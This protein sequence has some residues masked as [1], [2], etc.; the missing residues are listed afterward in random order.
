LP[1]RRTLSRLCRRRVIARLAVLA[2]LPLALSMC[3]TPDDG[4][5]ATASTTCPAVTVTRTGSQQTAVNTR[6]TNGTWNLRGAYWNKNAPRP[7]GYPVRSD[8]WTRGCIWGGKV[9]GGVPRSWTRDKWYDARDGGIR[10]GGDA[11]RQTMTA[12]AG[13]FLRIQDAFVADY[14]DAYDPD[15]A[16]WSSTTYLD[17]V[18]A[19][20]IRDDC[21]E[22]ESR[23]HNLVMTNSLLDGCFTAFAERPSG[24]TSGTNGSGPQS[25]T[26][27]NSLVYV[28]PQPLGP[29]YCDATRVQLGRCHPTSTPG[30]WLGAYGI[31]KWSN[32]AASHVTVKN[33][34]F[35]LDMP[36]Y[37]SCQSQKW[38][39]GT[40]Q[41]VTLV[42][43]GKGSYSTAGGCKNTLPAGVRLTT[44]VGVWNAA[45]SAWL[46]R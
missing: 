32:Q 39:A 42:W 45:K 23:P 9:F 40:Y 38:P 28:Q 36:S 25:F 5:R 14:E 31:W 26:V 17:H 13:N 20:Y 21:I 4:P 22:N 29:G 34:V 46:A 10:M 30:V 6:S 1:V 3:A 33:T 35:R 37:S 12:T 8:A 7:I 2:V 16:G 15:S 11:F 24:S 43:T 41:N 18:V 27:L 19:K 44:D